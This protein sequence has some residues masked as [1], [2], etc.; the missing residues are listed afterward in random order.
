MTLVGQDP[1]DDGPDLRRAVLD[2]AETVAHG[3][4]NG[5]LTAADLDRLVAAQAD[6]SRHR[7][8]YLRTL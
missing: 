2:A 8:A 4:A 5:S 1:A 3:R 6:Y 7:R